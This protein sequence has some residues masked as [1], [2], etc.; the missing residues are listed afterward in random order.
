MRVYLPATVTDLT[1]LPTASNGSVRF[2]IAAQTGFTVTNALVNALPG[3]DEEELEWAAF[4]AAEQAAANLLVH[5]AAA[6]PLRV[7]L[8]VEVPTTAISEPQ[9]TKSSQPAEVSVS[10]AP[11]AEL[12]AIHVDEPA[13]A[14]LIESFRKAPDSA[15]ALSA[16]LDADLLWYHPSEID[17]IPLTTGTT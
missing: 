16:V 3:A 11:A 13:T 9:Q 17:Q 15:S 1:H 14:P 10:A 7:V 12:A 2:P 6:P 4:V 5:D 8:S